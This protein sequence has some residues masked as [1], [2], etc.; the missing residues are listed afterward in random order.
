MTATTTT[1][2][3][4]LAAWA[5]AEFP[6]T[7]D[8]D[9]FGKSGV[10]V[11]DD[12]RRAE[13]TVH[14]TRTVDDYDA[15]TVDLVSKTAGKITSETF[16]FRDFLPLHDVTEASGNHRS[17]DHVNHIHAWVSRH[18]TYPTGQKCGWY[19]AVPA[20][21]EQLSSAIERWIDLYR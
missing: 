15:L 2:Y 16:R 20:H 10:H 9:W 4:T 7:I 11:L 1:E 17:I 3:T 21:P 5:A 13:I 18:S 14:S 8:I 12:D 6:W 19:I